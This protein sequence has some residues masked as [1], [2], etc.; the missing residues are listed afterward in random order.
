MPVR[1]RTHFT[2]PGQRKKCPPDLEGKLRNPLCRKELE[3]SKQ[4]SSKPGPIPPGPK[5]KPGPG[6]GQGPGPG[7]GPGPDPTPPDQL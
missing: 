4:G 6:P 3:E 7:P 5:P 2:D 1:H